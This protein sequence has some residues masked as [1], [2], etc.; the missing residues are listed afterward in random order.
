MIVRLIFLESVIDLELHHILQVGNSHEPVIIMIAE[1]RAL[2][3]DI[4]N[5][6]ETVSPHFAEQAIANA[7]IGTFIL[8]VVQQSTKA[9]SSN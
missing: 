8:K 1:E 7:N 4:N 2:F 9:K 6:H 5:L 3:S